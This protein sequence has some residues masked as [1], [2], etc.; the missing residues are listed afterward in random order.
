M[1]E[2][3]DYYTILGVSRDAS[4]EDIKRAYRRLA[5]KHHPDLNKDKIKES[6]EKFKEISEAYEV[7]FDPEKKANY[8]KFGQ[9]GVNFGPGGFDWSDF[10]RYSDVED[11]FGDLLKNFFGGRESAGPGARARAG[12]SPFDIF[13]SRGTDIGMDI[14][15]GYDRVRPARGSDL[16]YDLEIDLE[17]AVKGTKKEV[18]IFKEESCPSCNGTGA[19]SGGIEVCSACS[20][21]GQMRKVQRQGFAQFISLSVCPRCGGTGQEIKNPCEEC[22]G[23]GKIRVTKQISVKIPPGVDSGNRLRIAGE[24]GVGERGGPPGDLFV[25]VRVKEHEFFRR[26]GNNL[27]CEIPV[28]FTQLVFGDDIEVMTIDGKSKSARIK[29]PAG[30]QSGTNFRLKNQGMPDMKGYGRGDMIVRV[31]VV[32][33]KKLSKRQRELLHEFD[34]DEDKDKDKDEEEVGREKQKKSFFGW[35][36]ERSGSQSRSE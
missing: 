29:V 2:K 28:R 1:T 34:K 15:M 26:V 12:T 35:S 16:R 22:D 36:R 19:S 14:N 13:F 25:L 20:G 4:Q 23:S 33:P 8:D 9:A 3:K 6:E 18:S 30:T 27:F 21:S 31:N 17:D 10:T 5:K 24:G 32:T 7:L 11:I